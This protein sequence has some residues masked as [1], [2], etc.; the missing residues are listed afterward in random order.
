MH[1]LQRHR[2]FVFLKISSQRVLFCQLL[3]IDRWRPSIIGLKRKYPI[4]GRNGS[5]RPVSPVDLHTH[6]HEVAESA[7][8]VQR[9]SDKLIRRRQ[10]L[11]VR[12]VGTLGRDELRHLGG[13][14]DVGAFQG[15][16]L[17][18]PQAIGPRDRGDPGS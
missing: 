12:V 9:G 8:D 14:V 6:Q 4:E 11:R 5:R 3:R 15:F 10:H 1:R 17:E 13:H 18:C 16:L 7:D 2:Q